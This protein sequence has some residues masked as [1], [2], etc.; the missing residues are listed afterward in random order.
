MKTMIKWLAPGI[1]AAALLL[2]ACN[3]NN[4]SSNDPNI[5]PG[6]SKVGIYM[7]DAPVEFSKV[8]IDIRQVAVLVDSADK[9]G[10]DDRDDQWDDSYCGWHR[11]RENKSTF[12]DT[13]DITPGVYDLLQLRNG[14]DTLL[15]SGLIPTGK[16]LKV[17]ITLGADNTIYTDSTT[18]YPLEVFGPHPYFTVN[19]RRVDVSAASGN[20]FKLWLDFNLERSVFFWNGE[21]LLK[22]YIVVFN[23]Q[24]QAKLKGQVSPRKKVALITAFSNTDT[25]YAV[26]DWSNGNYLIRN[27]PAG[28]YSIRFRGRDGYKDTTITNITVESGKTV[29]VPDVTLHP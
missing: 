27:V 18:H 6:K 8:L 14:V 13:L 16:I 22:P 17:K 28:S 29:K 23:D 3:K 10:D 4:S 12:W 26:P 2:F 11:T 24:V 1:G 15:A 20:D 7:M 21:F 5:P 19:V 9:Q 25:L